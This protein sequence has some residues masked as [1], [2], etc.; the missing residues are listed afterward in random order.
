MR[1][2]SENGGYPL[3]YLE[4]H[5]PSAHAPRIYLSAG[6]H[7]DES[8]STEALLAWA[9]NNSETLQSL[10]LLIFPCLNPW[11]LVHNKRGDADD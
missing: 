11:G 7:G 10:Q 2:F 4:T 5:S 8:A 1:R 6:I 3:Y 9:E